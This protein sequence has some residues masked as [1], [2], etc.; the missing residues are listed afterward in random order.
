[1]CCVLLKTKGYSHQGVLD[2]FM[3]AV[4]NIIKAIAAC[5]LWNERS[6][7]LAGTLL[8]TPT[9]GN[10]ERNTYSTQVFHPWTIL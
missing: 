3:V 7:E 9:A 8:T 6:V 10:R 1:M 2:L 4:K 5:D